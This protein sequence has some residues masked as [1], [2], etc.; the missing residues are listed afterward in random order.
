MKKRERRK[1]EF[2]LNNFF[3]K[4]KLIMNEIESV[5]K[6]QIRAKLESQGINVDQINLLDDLDKFNIQLD[7]EEQES[8]YI[9][10]CFF[11]QF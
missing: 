1:K 7:E 11:F 10:I 2:F 4:C 9:S 6:E 3:L 8:R 5:L